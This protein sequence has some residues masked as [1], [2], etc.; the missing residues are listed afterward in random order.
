VT[1]ESVTTEKPNFA[2][3]N[4]SPL[5]DPEI[6]NIQWESKVRVGSLERHELL[7]TVIDSL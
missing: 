2:L 6:V 3:C 4:N 7:G 1:I 5:S